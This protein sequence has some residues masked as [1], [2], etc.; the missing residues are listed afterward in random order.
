MDKQEKTFS[1]RGETVTVRIEQYQNNKRPAIQL[2]DAEG[3]PYATATINVPSNE[4]D[5]D[6]CVIKSYSENR[7]MYE[8]LLTNNIVRTADEWYLLP[9]G[10][11]APVCVLNPKEDWIMVNQERDPEWFKDVWEDYSQAD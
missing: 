6:L 5:N 9:H 4:V 1:F 10:D 11:S 3:F 2:V 8:F 7:G